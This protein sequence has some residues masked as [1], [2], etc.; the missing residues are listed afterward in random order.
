[1]ELKLLLSLLKSYWPQIAA[2]VGAVALG[3][4]LA[5][6]L[7]GLKL[8]ALAVEFGKYRN[9]VEQQAIEARRAAMDKEN[10]W[11]MEVENAR[12]N[13]QTRETKLK[14]S[15]AAAQSAVVSLRDDI[16]TL[17]ARLAGS[18]AATAIDTAATLGELLGQCS[19][20][21]RELAEIADRHASDAKTLIEAWPR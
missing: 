21:Y 18:S 8:D 2:F 15:A 20:A 4:G 14:K 13:A 7:Q 16:R 3:F 11:R 10:F 1:M 19:E 6:N 17:Q 5:W 12:V 9:Q